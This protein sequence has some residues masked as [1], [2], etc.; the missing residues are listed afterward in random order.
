MVLRVNPLADND[1]QLPRT[2]LLMFSNRLLRL[3]DGL[4]CVQPVQIDF[5]RCAIFVIGMEDPISCLLVELLHLL[6]VFVTLVA[7]LLG[8]SPVSLC[9]CLVRFIKALGH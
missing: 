1:P 6:L 5:V 8:S 2:L 4:F 9:V 3:C 7:Q